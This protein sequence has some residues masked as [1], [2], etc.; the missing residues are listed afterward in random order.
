M[1]GFFLPGDSLLFVAGTLVQQGVFDIHP[2]VLIALLS[3]AAIAGNS[4]GYLIGRKVGRRLFQR[5]NSRFFRQEYLHEAEIFYEKYGGKTIMLAMFVPIV[6]AFT[7][8]VAGIAGMPYRKFVLFNVI[9]AVVWTSSLTLLG[10]FAGDLIHRLGIN[11]EV[12]VLVIIF[13]S[14]LPGI[15]HL[16]QSPN[17]RQAIKK[18]I[19]SLGRSAK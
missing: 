14:L 16:L 2:A 13:L 11:I 17:R 9:G 1:V 4:T 3:L 10:Y 12:T 15:I 18:H 6:R 8:V 19:K 5:P 7:A